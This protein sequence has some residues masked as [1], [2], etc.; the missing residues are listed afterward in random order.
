MICGLEPLVS[1]KNFG[2]MPKKAQVPVEMPLK[3]LIVARSSFNCNIGSLRT[4]IECLDTWRAKGARFFE[5]KVL[6]DS[7]LDG[8]C[9]TLSQ[10]K[11]VA[12]DVEDM[13][14]LDLDSTLWGGPG[15]FKCPEKARDDGHEECQLL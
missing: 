7:C 5:S 11:L 8:R 4:G 2:F 3:L 14:M 9:Q 6:H 13:E 10:V 1:T 12:P 15:V